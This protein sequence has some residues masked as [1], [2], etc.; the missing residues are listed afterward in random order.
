MN[1]CVNCIAYF[2]NSIDNNYVIAHRSLT[3][4]ISTAENEQYELSTKYSEGVA[5]ILR[6]MKPKLEQHSLFMYTLYLKPNR[7]IRI[8]DETD[9][10]DVQWIDMPYHRHV[11]Y[12]DVIEFLTHFWAPMPHLTF[13]SI[14]GHIRTAFDRIDSNVKSIIIREG[15]LKANA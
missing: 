13:L 9:P 5:R 15:V 11:W 4:P 8:W 12:S 6:I 2:P 1:G 7:T 14:Q 10:K 3:K